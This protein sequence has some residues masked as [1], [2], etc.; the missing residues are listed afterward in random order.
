MN[1]PIMAIG[2]KKPTG[3]FASTPN[4]SIRYIPAT[5]HR[6]LGNQTF[7]RTNRSSPFFREKVP[8]TYIINAIVPQKIKTESGVAALAAT[9]NMR[10]VD[11]AIAE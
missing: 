4:P 6:L 10:L 2:N 8:R 11:K 9:S 7:S 1:K 3:P 5:Y